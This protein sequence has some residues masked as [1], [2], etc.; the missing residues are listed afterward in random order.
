MRTELFSPLEVL[1]LLC[2]AADSGPIL[3]YIILQ[4]ALTCLVADGAI[5]GM[6]DK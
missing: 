3:V 4:G 6:V 2:K 5:E 1:L